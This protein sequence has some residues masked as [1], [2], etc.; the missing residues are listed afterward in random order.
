M[1][2][3]Q[4]LIDSA[5]G[6]VLP[7]DGAAREFEKKSDS[8][9]GLLN[10]TMLE[11]PDLDDLVGSGG[12]EMMKDNHKNHFRYI[13]SLFKGYDPAE[14]VDTVVWVFVTY[15]KHG[16]SVSYWPA[17]LSEARRVMR[18]ILTVETYEQ[19]LPLYQWLAA[20]VEDFKS[21]SDRKALNM[22]GE[23]MRHVSQ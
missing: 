20:H 7:S 13:V 18:P 19:V 15:R 3:K 1:N 10:I 8:L 23:G 12:R 22:E 5:S 16:F 6:I 14:F 21:L 2:E 9:A 11:R 17:M 4:L